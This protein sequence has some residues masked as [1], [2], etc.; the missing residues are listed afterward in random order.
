M[1]LDVQ[2]VIGIKTN[3]P[4][5]IKIQVLVIMRIDINV[6]KVITKDQAT[7]DI[8]IM[9]LIVLLVI[10]LHKEVIDLDIIQL[11]IRLIILSKHWI[12]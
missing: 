1:I 6:N 2:I 7:M 10:N 12:F 9:E 11:I 5:T 8:Q 4:E 3:I